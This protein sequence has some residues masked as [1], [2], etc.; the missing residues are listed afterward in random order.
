MSK[1]IHLIVTTHQGKMY[2]EVCDYIV[3]KAPNGDFGVYP[4]HVPTITS[5]DEGYLKLVF[6]KNTLYMCLTSA[7][8]EFSNNVF[9]VLAQEVHIGRTIES[10]KEHL[11]ISRKE[12]LEQN[13]KLEA[14][15]ALSEKEIIDNI[16]KA[17]AGNL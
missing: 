10:A 5:F 4:N 6:E 15:L 1:T 13:R 14:D 9:S 16:K 2:D 7:L 17:K 8:I 3:V 12:R 11:E